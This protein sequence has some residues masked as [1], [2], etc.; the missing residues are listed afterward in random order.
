MV[1]DT[2][3]QETAKPDSTPQPA[4]SGP[5]E[6]REG[7]PTTPAE[8]SV[9]PSAP[10]DGGA[11]ATPTVERRRR[12]LERS[13]LLLGKGL[14]TGGALT[15]EQRL[16][17][18]DTWL[19][20]GLAAKDFG[21]L[22]GLSKA[23]L[24]SWK[25]RFDEEGPGGLVDHPRGSRKGSRLPEVTKRAI[26]MMAKANP[27]WGYQRLSDMLARGPALP[28][29]PQAVSRVLAEAGIE[30]KETS[31]ERH[32]PLVHR[33]ERAR[34]NQMWQTDLF[35]FLLKRQNRRLYLVGFMDDHSR[36]MVSYGVHASAAGSLVIEVFRAG[37]AAYG[38]PEEVLTDNGP[39][40]VTWRGKSVFSQEMV[41]QGVKQIVARRYHPQT[42]GKIERFWGTL[43][44]ECL[45]D[46]VML[47]VEDARKRIG[48]FIDDYNFRRPHQSLE[49]LV[50]ADRFFGA[51]DPV[52]KA[53]QARVAENAL[54]LAKNGVPREPFYL[55]GQVG[56][57]PVSM[58]TEGDRVIVTGPDGERKEVDLAAA[59]QPTPPSLPDPVCPHGE[60]TGGAFDEPEPD[61]STEAPKE[62]GEA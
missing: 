48:H 28:A 17:L 43:W 55:T 26:L 37:V 46:A 45:H 58:H 39:Q 59:P 27:E 15:P 23:T 34:P 6:P 19:R 4:S 61:A 9:T 62:G 8:P 12:T 11:A 18:L 47:D 24:Y 7:P 16:L 20:S 10:A 35:T 53:M 2:R 40:Y 30:P 52:K 51:V 54:S 22:I 42:L 36:Y 33:F 41:K 49:G 29:S 13:P 50:P 60:P 14:G 32:P 5:P 44:K 1:E 56:G 57:K 38:P 25:K 31:V 21:E 3:P